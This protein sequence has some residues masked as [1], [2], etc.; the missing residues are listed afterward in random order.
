ML[1]ARTTTEV[2]DGSHG[3]KAPSKPGRGLSEHLPSLR[4]QKETEPRNPFK[5][6]QRVGGRCHKGRVR[7]SERAE[8]KEKEEEEEA[9]QRGSSFEPLIWYN[10]TN[11]ALCL[12]MLKR[13]VSK[14]LRLPAKGTD[15]ASSP[16][17]EPQYKVE[18]WCRTDG[19]AED[20]SD[21]VERL[22][23]L[24][25]VLLFLAGLLG[26]GFHG[27]LEGA[28]ERVELVGRLLQ[29]EAGHK[30]LQVGGVLVILPIMKEEEEGQS[31]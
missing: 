25:V 3:V 17:L 2:P 14:M 21:G 4:A 28:L 15:G 22:V 23:S 31:L 9:E 5:A 20:D 16:V 6:L 8:K 11:A 13:C 7:K 12:R 19:A 29:Q 24:F 18:L 10:H 27:A 1:S 30:L 26:R